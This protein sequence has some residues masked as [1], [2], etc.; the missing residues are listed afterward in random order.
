MARVILQYI[1][2]QRQTHVQ[3]HGVKPAPPTPER[4]P[5][6]EPRPSGS[7]DPAA[8]NTQNAGSGG[9]TKPNRS[10]PPKNP[11][12]DPYDTY[13]IP[14][15]D[16]SKFQLWVNTQ[17]SYTVNEIISSTIVTMRHDFNNTF[18]MTLDQLQY[19]TF[20]DT[21]LVGSDSQTVHESD[22]RELSRR[23]NEIKNGNATKNSPITIDIKPSNIVKQRIQHCIGELEDFKSIY[24]NGVYI[25][26]LPETRASLKYLVLVYYCREVLFIAKT[27]YEAIQRNNLSAIRTFLST[28]EIQE[29]FE[30]ALGNSSIHKGF[31]VPKGCQWKDDI[32]IPMLSLLDILDDTKPICSAA[33]DASILTHD[34]SEFWKQSKMYLPSAGILN[35]SSLKNDVVDE[36]LTSIFIWF[37]I[38]FNE[39]DRIFIRI[40]T[41]KYLLNLN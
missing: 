20:N 19:V 21:N 14:N 36:S 15:I 16:W 3:G 4:K 31:K 39:E 38:A 33:V 28:K 41:C 12:D 37:M 2:K 8:D 10:D 23:L 40:A 11:D 32:Y 13:Y 35:S 18:D 26:K 22:F 27:K 30:K 5:G 9:Q 17:R 25:L 29:R 34:T 6:I 24:N 1:G 7:A